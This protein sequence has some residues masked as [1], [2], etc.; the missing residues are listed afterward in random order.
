MFTCKSIQK[1]PWIFHSS[2]KRLYWKKQYHVNFLRQLDCSL[3]LLEKV[4][5]GYRRAKYQA[6]RLVISSLYFIHSSQ[7]HAP[8]K[9]NFNSTAIRC[10]LTSDSG[11]VR[12]Q[13]DS[14][15][16]TLSKKSIEIVN[17]YFWAPASSLKICRTCTMTV[18]FTY[19]TFF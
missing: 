13:G 5:S 14:R 18:R 12:G 7:F 3:F 9:W 2:T 10:V 1:E 4:R 8:V 17:K 19:F 16:V 11:D 15:S 6:G